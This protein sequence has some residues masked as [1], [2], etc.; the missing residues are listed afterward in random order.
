MDMIHQ[1]ISRVQLGLLLAI[2]F[3]VSGFF[4]NCFAVFL[5]HVSGL[6][7][8][9]DAKGEPHCRYAQSDISNI[10]RLLLLLLLFVVH[11]QHMGLRMFF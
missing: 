2:L 8:V 5:Q 7:L 10:C 3:L 6:R 11:S 1:V 4:E 9:L